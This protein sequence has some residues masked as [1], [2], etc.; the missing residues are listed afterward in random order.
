L[1]DEAADAVAETLVEGDLLGHTTHGLQLLPAYLREIDEGR[2]RTHGEPTILA[3][4]GSVV[5]WDGDY[6]P[7]P[8]LVRQA[9]DL[10]FSR[11]S[12]HKLVTIVLRRSQHIACLAAYLQLATERGYLIL[13]MTSDPSVRSV[14]PYGGVA[15]CF[16]PNP[17]AVG[18]PTDGDPILMDICASTTTNAMATK[19]ARTGR[20][21]PGA[22]MI[23]GDGR[24]T[25]DPKV[26]FG[27]PPGAILPLGG[28]ELGHKGFALALM[29]EALT[30]ALG[31]YGRA[32]GVSRWGASVFLQLIDPDGFGGRAAFVRETGWLAQV[33][34]NARVPTGA[35][36]VR[37]PG[38][39]G[40]RLRR[41]QLDS[42]LQLHPEIMES[43]M[44]WSKKLGVDSPKPLSRPS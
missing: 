20:T 22:W 9:L 29:V 30:S 42:G 18:I 10:A 16:T 44:P 14:T 19:L 3:D 35:P 36:P 32:D 11:V 1:A 5:T 15:G 40:L 43:L 27:D 4:H 38:E 21:L 31:G 12:R 7:G 41:R 2:M 26:M 23:D 37:L 13:L 24:P 39:R 8:W 33:C 34:R 6:L 28:I 17:I 25:D